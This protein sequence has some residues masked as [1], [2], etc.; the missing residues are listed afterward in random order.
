MTNFASE[1]SRTPKHRKSSIWLTALVAVIILIA[2]LINTPPGI[3]GKADAVG[4]AIC[5]RIDERSFQ[6]GGR[7]IA[8]CARCTGMYLGAMLGLI[9]QS[10]LGRRRAEWPALSIMMALGVFVLAFGIDGG[11]SA[12]KLY[13]GRNL[14]YTPN[15]TLRMVTGT[16]MGVFISILLLPTFH[17]TMWTRYSHKPSIQSWKSFGLLLGLGALLIVFVLTE[18][19]WVLWPLSILSAIG[20]L[21]MLTM[22]YSMILVIVF[23]RENKIENIRELIPWLLLGFIVG[24]LQISAIDLGR[25]LLT[26]TWDGLHLLIG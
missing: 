8:M 16:G 10:C 4:Y 22:L 17:Q 15:N 9:F 5:H 20:V 26:G 25:F 1:T 23:K 3:L 24:L 7:Q 11:N 6:I 21:V 19:P 12:A 13:L 2:W 14:L 18:L